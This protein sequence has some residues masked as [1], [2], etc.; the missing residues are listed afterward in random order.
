MDDQQ[1]SRKNA[2]ERARYALTKATDPEKLR[3]RWKR[4]RELN[5]QAT[6]ARYR[7]W[8]DTHQ[9]HLKAYQEATRERRLKNG[10]E[11][12]RRNP[13]NGRA[14]VQKWRGKHP[15]KVTAYREANK[16]KIE[17]RTKEW[18]RANPDMVRENTRKWHAAHPDVV[19]NWRKANPEAWRA[20]VQTRRALMAS[21]EGRHTGA[22]LR[23][24]LKQQN[25]RCCYCQKSIRTK[26]SVDHI[27]PLSKGGTNWIANIQLLCCP[28]NSAK[29][30][31]DPIEYARR[32]G[33]LI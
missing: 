24:L 23:S 27:Q 32:K 9:E 25:W 13:E 18:K 2:R 8:Y 10:K 1:R 21:A 19:K 4:D 15:E 16:E 29:Q 12:A 14:R 17:Q 11:W 5:P 28:C 22:D 20:Q 6:A 31:T 7:R 33:L 3:T 26:Y 30:D